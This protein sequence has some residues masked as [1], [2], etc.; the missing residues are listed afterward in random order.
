MMIATEFFE[1]QCHGER[2]GLLFIVAQPCPGRPVIMVHT[3][4]GVS[5]SCSYP[6]SFSHFASHAPEWSSGC[7]GFC[8]TRMES[9][10]RLF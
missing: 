5:R 1:G 2:K 8:W 9:L 7:H 4:N 10:R 3:S 6:Q